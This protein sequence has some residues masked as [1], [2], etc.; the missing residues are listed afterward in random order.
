MEKLSA[1]DLPPREAH[2]DRPKAWH[3]E[4]ARPSESSDRAAIVSI[5]FEY[6]HPGRA[7]G[8]EWSPVHQIE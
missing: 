5:R 2:N 7:N 8:G 1:D 6:V 4:N 3:W